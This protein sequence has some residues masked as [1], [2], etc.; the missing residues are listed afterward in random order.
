M[1]R[2]NDSVEKQRGARALRVPLSARGASTLLSQRTYK[3]E[4]YL[5]NALALCTRSCTAAQT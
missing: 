2:V 1:I 3:A 5:Q 4:L